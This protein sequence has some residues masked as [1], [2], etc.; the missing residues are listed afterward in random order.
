[1]I[2][3][4]RYQFN[5]LFQQE[6]TNQCSNEKCVD[7]PLANDEDVHYTC[8]YTS[9][10]YIELNTLLLLLLFLILF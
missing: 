6:K 8:K 2:V 4:K 1:M 9:I 3:L 10:G 7:N 5:S